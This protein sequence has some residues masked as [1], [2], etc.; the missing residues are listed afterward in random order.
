M[1]IKMMNILLALC[2][3]AMMASC[4]DDLSTTGGEFV[5]NDDTYSPAKL[6][7]IMNEHEMKSVRFFTE[8]ADEAT[9]MA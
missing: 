3:T 7:N 9:G 8:G 6:R 5:E 2:V 4:V 1:K